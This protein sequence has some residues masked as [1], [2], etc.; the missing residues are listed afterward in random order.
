MAFWYLTEQGTKVSKKGEHLQIRIGERL[1]G[2]PLIKEI[3][4]LLLFGHIQL[5]TE[6]MLAIAQNEGE[7]AFLSLYG[8]YK[9]RICPALGANSKLRHAQHQLWADPTRALKFASI[10]IHA[11]LCNAYQTLYSY[12]RNS[13]SEFLF[14]RMPE[15]KKE[16][17]DLNREPPT[18]LA[19]LRGIEGYSARLYFEGFA[20][21]LC[22]PWKFPGRKYHPST[23]PVNALL[24]L[25]Y[26]LVSRE[27]ESQ[28]HAAG[29]D[30]AIGIFHSIEYGR[31][32]LALDL[33]EEFRH[34]L[35]DRLVLRVL[36][37]RMFDIDDFIHHDASPQ[38]F[39]KD[40]ALKIF[41]R[42]FEEEM[43]KPHRSKSSPKT[44]TWRSLI[45]ERVKNLRRCLEEDLDPSSWFWEE[46]LDEIPHQL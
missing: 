33:L 16:I 25:C 22:E 4:C 11:K 6:A 40:T 38:L 5:S 24:S 36:N 44:Q 2:D 9:A 18:N 43:R 23:D 42:L 20:Q 35:C 39:F 37:T 26:S 10:L 28:L 13:R 21:C 1:L 46:D 45:R 15:L 41:L 29:F 32:S 30:P 12:A 19:S 31:S 34:P 17:N 3:E 14:E 7:I 27:I 8:Q